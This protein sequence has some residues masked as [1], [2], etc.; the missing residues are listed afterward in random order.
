M[1]HMPPGDILIIRNLV[2]RQDEWD[3]SDEE[4]G[5]LTYFFHDAPRCV[6]CI[7]SRGMLIYWRSVPSGNAMCIN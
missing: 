5:K 6:L 4:K 7:I 3:D 1:Q 2:H